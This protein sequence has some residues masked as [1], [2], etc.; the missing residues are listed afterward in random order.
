MTYQWKENA[1]VRG[2]SAQMAGERLSELKAQFGAVTPQVVLDD[3]RPEGSPLHTAFEWNDEIAA[4][5][6]RLQQASYVIRS[7]VMQPATVGATAVRVFVHVES[8]DEESE[9]GE[10]L[11][12]AEVLGDD[13]LRRRTLMRVLNNA[14]NELRDFADAPEFRQVVT[15]IARVRARLEG[16]AAQSAAA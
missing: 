11:T 16:P 12:R 2:V 5:R 15:T 6:F 8:E 9:R 1:R 10:Y 4:E 7:I 3:A 13:E 14:A